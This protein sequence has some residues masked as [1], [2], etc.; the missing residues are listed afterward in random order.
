MLG[1]RRFV[2]TSQRASVGRSRILGPIMLCLQR[3]R[4]T[5]RYSGA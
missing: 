3:Y 1:L 2:K 4:E 5:L